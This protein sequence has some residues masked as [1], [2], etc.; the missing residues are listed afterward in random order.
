M[1]LQSKSI[2]LYLFLGVA[3]ATSIVHAQE[4]EPHGWLGNETLKTRFGDFEFKNGH[5]VGDT[6][7]RL[8]DLQTINRATEV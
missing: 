2:C 4:A 3:G 5:P 6:T 7:Q 8:E 1:R